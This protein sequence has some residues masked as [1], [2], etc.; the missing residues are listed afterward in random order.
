MQSSRDKSFPAFAPGLLPL[1]SLLV[2]FSLFLATQRLEAFAARPS[3]SPPRSAFSEALALAPVPELAGSA[4]RAVPMEYEI[5]RGE[6]QRAS[7]DRPRARRRTRPGRPPQPRGHLDLRGL[8]AGERYACLL[9]CA[10]SL[11]VLP[12]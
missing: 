11:A 6:T 4:K 5:Q 2:A 10:T 3:R 7:S 9:R 8:R 12:L 1:S